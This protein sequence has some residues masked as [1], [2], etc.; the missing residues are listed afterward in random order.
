[1][2]KPTAKETI[3]YTP[4]FKHVYLTKDVG[5]KY[6]HKLLQDYFKELTGIKGYWTFYHD[7]TDD[8]SH[9]YTIDNPMIKLVSK[10]HV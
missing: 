10:L 1:M 7:Y 5:Q 6:A 3:T 9:H 4:D 2:S 8:Y